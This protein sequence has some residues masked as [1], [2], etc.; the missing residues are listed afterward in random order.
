MN[1]EGSESDFE[2]LLQ[3]ARVS[4]RDKSFAKYV[5]GRI[6]VAR[7][8]GTHASIDHGK[9]AVEASKAIEDDLIKNSHGK[10]V[11][12]QLRTEFRTKYNSELQVMLP[13][14]HVAVRELRTIATKAFKRQEK[15]S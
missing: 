14:E 5:N 10:T 13:S 9:L 1:D 8:N 15:L 11:L 12:K 7:E 2:D 4:A 6:G 3:S